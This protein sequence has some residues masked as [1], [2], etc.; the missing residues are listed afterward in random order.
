MKNKK[1][2]PMLQIALLSAIIIVL[3]TVGS[4]IKLPILGTSVSLVLVPI[5]I[6]AVMLGAK[7]GAFLGFVFGA[8]TLWAGISGSDAF[9]ALLFQ[10]QPFATAL[11]CLGKGTLAGLVAGLLVDLSR[12]KD[13]PRVGRPSAMGIL[14][15]TYAVPIINT[16]L[17]ILGGL[18]LVA[19][20]LQKNFVAEGQTL[21]YF[22][23]IGCAGINF[24][25]ELLLN[26][27]VSPAI[28]T[29]VLAVNRKMGLREG[30]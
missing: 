17:F 25:F 29:I 30:Q 23:V 16:G 18:T 7:G 9:T 11:I 2:L 10:N 13:G 24:V 14:F 22:L 12:K 28:G 4:F 21:L 3:Q 27:A 19:D 1:L 8:V 15:A 20:T 5:T 26:I 6:G